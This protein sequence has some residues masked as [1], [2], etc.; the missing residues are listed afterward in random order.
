M[1]TNF[2][3][4]RGYFLVSFLN[5]GYIIEADLGFSIMRG[6]Y[7]NNRGLDFDVSLLL[8]G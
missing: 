2:C 3:I 6:G 1:E 4:P 7:T 8:I 5:Q